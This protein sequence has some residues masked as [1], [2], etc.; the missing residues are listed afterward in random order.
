MNTNRRNA[1]RL[2]KSAES[3]HLDDLV[4]EAARGRAIR[5][6]IRQTLDDGSE[7]IDL[8]FDDGTKEAFVVSPEDL[9]TAGNRALRGAGDGR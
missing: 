8:L 1:D 7:S 5:S 4:R 2:R 9:R 6:E 3:A